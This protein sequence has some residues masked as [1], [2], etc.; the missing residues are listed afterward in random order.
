MDNQIRHK[1][2]RP[3]H[4]LALQALLWYVLIWALPL[5]TRYDY[6]VLIVLAG[7][8]VVTLVMVIF[9]LMLSYPKL[10]LE[11][12]DFWD[13]FNIYVAVFIG[14]VFIAVFMVKTYNE[15]DEP[16]QVT[17]EV[18]DQYMTT[19]N[20]QPLFYVT[21]KFV[22]EFDSTNQFTSRVP[23]Y[24]YNHFGEFKR[25]HLEYPRRN[26]EGVSIVP[27]E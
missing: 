20:Q 4:L 6:L 13:G 16:I 18:V 17:G 11:Q 19:E 15:Y 7:G 26:P 22:D 25:V 14:I 12:R 5:Y 8:M 2:I 24:V 1:S 10:S 27:L 9:F 23:E 21:I 3:W